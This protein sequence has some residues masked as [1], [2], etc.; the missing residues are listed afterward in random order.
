MTAPA[1]PAGADRGGWRSLD[2]RS[3]TSTTLV[4]A[5]ALV[6][7]AVPVAVGL[8]VSGLGVG[9]ILLWTVGGAVVGTV[10]TAV[11]EAARLTVTRYRVDAHRIERRVRFL[12]STTTTLSTHRVRNVEITAD[13]VQR[14]LGIAT[15]KLASGET[16]GARMT[17]ASLD[18]SEAEELRRRLLADRAGTAGSELARLDPRWIRYAPASL[19]T[20]LFGLLGFGI[21][22]Q[23]A[24]WFN[25]VPAVV[26]WVWDRV[27]GL[28]LPVLAIGLVVL[29]LLIGTVAAAT[30]LE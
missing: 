20:P 11:A 1:R 14:R 30:Q 15:V 5:A 22:L 25:A 6:A 19:M 12:S 10:A 21:V 29:T 17:L 8:L 18:R 16:D 26:G 24:D 7:T 27:G 28:P 23:V 13:V 9:W 4:V 3:I 2:R